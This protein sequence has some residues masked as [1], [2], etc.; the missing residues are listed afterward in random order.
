M[1]RWRAPQVIGTI[2]VALAMG[3]AGSTRKTSVLQRQPDTLMVFFEP[4]GSVPL[5]APFKDA[6]IRFEEARIDYEQH[7]RFTEA[8]RRF[9]DAARLLQRIGGF[10]ANTAAA[11]RLSCYRNA[12]AAYS[13]AGDLAEGRAA[14]GAAAQADPAYADKIHEIIGG[15]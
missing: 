8:A 10:Y 15:S 4:E 3:C 13:A 12:W 5:P 11:N 1:V 6:A 7:H 14:L 2:L 9:L